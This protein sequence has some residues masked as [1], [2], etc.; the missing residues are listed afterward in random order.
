MTNYVSYTVFFLVTTF[1]LLVQTELG[2]EDQSQACDVTFYGVNEDPVWNWDTHTDELT[3]FAE[4]LKQTHCGSIRI[5][6]RW[7]VVEPTKGKW[8]FS[9]ID[10][11]VQMIPDDIQI[12]GTFLSVPEWASGVDPKKVEGWFDTYPPKDL[13]DWECYV[14]Q[15][16][17]N[18]KHRIKHWEIWNEENGV[19]FFRPLPDAKAYTELLKV[20]YKAAK[21]ADPD[22]VVV[23]GG[24]QMNGIIPNPWSKVK[25]SDYLEDLYEAGAGQFFDVCNIH[26]YVLPSEGAGYMMKLIQDT[27]SL[28]ARY[29]DSEKPLWITEVGCGATSPDAEKVQ[30][31]LLA[32]TFESA[33]KETRIKRVFWFLLRDMQSDLLGPEGSMGLF[34]YQGRPK[35]ALWAFLNATEKAH[36][37]DLTK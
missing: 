27:L 30:A 22:C 7:R 16:V 19:D 24:L 23:L 12:L 37:T 11:V 17:Q 18:Y 21:T 3:Q 25:V 32:D 15:T 36:D 26:P 5:P 20:A 1:M 9:V 34:S 6:I 29:G 28:M 4:M 13:S 33:S 10:R 8:D 2:A 35:P 31:Q 14:S